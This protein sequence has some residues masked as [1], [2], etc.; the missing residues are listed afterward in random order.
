[1]DF[2][3]PKEMSEAEKNYHKGVLGNAPS[4]N[5]ERQDNGLS[6][7]TKPARVIEQTGEILTSIQ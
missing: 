1:M 3:T 4:A 2:L 7:N 6:S 5:P